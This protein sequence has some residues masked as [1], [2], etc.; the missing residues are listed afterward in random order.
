M[1]NRTDR[2]DNN[3]TNRADRANAQLLGLSDL[4]ALSGPSTQ[5]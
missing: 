1:I 2:A 4:F 5:L 3:R